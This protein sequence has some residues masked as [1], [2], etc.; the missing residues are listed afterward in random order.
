MLDPILVQIPKDVAVKNGLSRMRLHADGQAVVI[1]G[2]RHCH[3]LHRARLRAEAT[4][5]AARLAIT[6]G[7]AAPGFAAAAGAMHAAVVGAGAVAS[8]NRILRTNA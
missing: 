7:F 8:C 2:T 6:A 3:L 5:G 4:G 1:A